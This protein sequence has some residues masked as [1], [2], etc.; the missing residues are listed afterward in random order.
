MSDQVF[1][2]LN[3]PETRLECE[4]GIEGDAKL[5]ARRALFHIFVRAKQNTSFT[6]A[7]HLQDIILA[8]Q[9]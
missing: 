8:R 4:R 7:R 6:L 9:D 1:G 2:K 3:C 5:M